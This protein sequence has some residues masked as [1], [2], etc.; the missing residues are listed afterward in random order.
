ME[1]LY[2]IW[3]TNNIF[4]NVIIMIFYHYPRLYCTLIGLDPNNLYNYAI[5]YSRINF[6]LTEGEHNSLLKLEKL[7][8]LD[9]CS[10][11][12]LTYS[13]PPRSFMD[14][15]HPLWDSRVPAGEDSGGTR[16]HVLWY[17]TAGD[18]PLSPG[19]GWPGQLDWDQTAS[20]ASQQAGAGDYHM[21]G[22]WES[23]P[24]KRQGIQLH[25]LNDNVIHYCNVQYVTIYR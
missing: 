11:C 13:L 22:R 8:L 15:I 24:L 12:N 23:S 2:T 4:R 9:L 20:S 18:I 16:L 3:K 14:N 21:P 1:I 5:H 17:A 6:N 10:L 19:P 7:Y 25:L